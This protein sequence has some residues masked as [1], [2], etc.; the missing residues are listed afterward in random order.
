MIALLVTHIPTSVNILTRASS[1]VEI[2]STGYQTA[3]ILA[4]SPDG[5]PV[6][7]LE[8]KNVMIPRPNVL[9][10]ALTQY[11]SNPI[12][13]AKAAR[14]NLSYQTVHEAIFE[15]DFVHVL[16]SR[17]QRNRRYLGERTL[18]NACRLILVVLFESR[19][20]FPVS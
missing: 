17:S 3:A 15:E 1:E 12:G 16:A 6:L 5:N 18:V 10:H 14:S 7:Q 4:T 8:P 11:E 20:A 13:R 2:K 19:V 9:Q